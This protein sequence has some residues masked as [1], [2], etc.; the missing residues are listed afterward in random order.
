[1]AIGYTTAKALMEMDIKVDAMP[2]D[3]LFEE[4]LITLARYWER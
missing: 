1:V 4:A 3:Y 2:E